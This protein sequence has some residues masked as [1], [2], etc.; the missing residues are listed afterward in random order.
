MPS[1]LNT[2][3]FRFIRF[4]YNGCSRVRGFGILGA[5]GQVEDLTAACGIVW[6]IGWC[7]APVAPADMAH[8]LGMF[9]TSD[10]AVKRLNRPIFVEIRPSEFIKLDIVNA[11][12]VNRQNIFV[13]GGGNGQCAVAGCWNNAGHWCTAPTPGCRC[14]GL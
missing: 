13:D 6:I 3:N 14:T 10:G 8:N 5:F 12:F 7:A 9:D 2:S 1:M 4:G 11:Q